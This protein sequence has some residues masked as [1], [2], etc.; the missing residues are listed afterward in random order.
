MNSNNTAIK[1]IAL[2]ILLL[3]GTLPGQA[4]DNMGIG[5]NNPHPSAK[6]DVSSTSQGLLIPRMTTTERDGIITTA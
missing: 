4:Q 2:F 5:T 3:S 6:L 1:V